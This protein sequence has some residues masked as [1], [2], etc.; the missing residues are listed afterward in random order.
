MRELGWLISEGPFGSR[1]T[2]L[3]FIS[4]GGLPTALP[5]AALLAESVLAVN[6]PREPRIPES[7]QQGQALRRREG[8]PPGKDPE[9]LLGAGPFAPS[10]ATLAVLPELDPLSVAW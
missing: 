9:R 4:G 1:T 6:N 10:S 2:K 5:A 7:G 3:V 8:A